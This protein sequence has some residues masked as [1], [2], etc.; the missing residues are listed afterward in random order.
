MRQFYDILKSI[1]QI[2]QGNLNVVIENCGND[3]MGELGSQI[4]TM[5]ENI[6]RLM[7]DNIKHETLVKNSEIRALQNQINAAFYLQCTGIYQD[8]G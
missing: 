6:R 5:L 3:E 2:Q 4:N 1:R 7:D 8:D